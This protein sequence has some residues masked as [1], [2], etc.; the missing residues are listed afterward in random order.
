MPKTSKI[1]ISLP[2]EALATIEREKTV[3]GLSRSEVIRKAVEMWIKSRKDQER[4][5]LYTRAYRD[6]PETRDEIEAA[7]KTAGI[8][9]REESW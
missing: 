4:G 1:S 8:V 5:E 3:S 6:M 9:M 7:R 2:E